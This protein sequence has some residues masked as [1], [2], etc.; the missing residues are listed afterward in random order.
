MVAYWDSG[1]R[2]VVANKA[3]VEWFG[4]EPDDMTGRLIREVLG[5]RVYAQ[6]LPHIEAVLAGR[7]QSF[8]RTLL[9]A[10]GHVRYTQAVYVPDTVGGEVRGFFV[11]VTDITRVRRRE[12]QDAALRRIALAAAAGTGERELLELVVDSMIELFDGLHASVVRFG[13]EGMEV[14]TL[15]PSLATVGPGD[16]PVHYL[17]GTAAMRVADTGHPQLVHFDEASAGLAA[18]VYR[19]GVR[20]G[21]SAPVMVNGRLW[22]A[23]GVGVRHDDGDGSEI[24]DRLA[25]FADA[26]ATSISSAAA[27]QALAEMASEDALTGLANRRSFEQRLAAAVEASG[28]HRHPVSLI[29]VDLDRLKEVNDAHG[30]AAGDAVLVEA[31]R[32]MRSVTRSGEVVART[33]GDEFAVLLVDADAGASAAAAERLRDVLSRPWPHGWPVTAS[34]GL[35]TGT[36]GRITAS[37]LSKLADEALYESKRAG[38]NTVTV[39]PP[40]A[41]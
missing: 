10:A 38:R 39:A 13:D 29:L 2:N 14:V 34:V 17:E 16:D 37:R 12:M 3:Y 8:E 11:L 30:H 23:I 26:A 18:E 21:A 33:G 5:E 1:Q 24:L 27:W 4:F 19:A 28:R 25:E 41:G 36:G 22:G 6:N 32:R 9:D 40:P 15:R 20:L 7:Q 31:A 35:A